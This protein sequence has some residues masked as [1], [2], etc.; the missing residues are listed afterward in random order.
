MNSFENRDNFIG[1]E[2]SPEDID[3]KIVSKGKNA[4]DTLHENIV[5]EKEKDLNLKISDIYGVDYDEASEIHIN[6]HNLRI[7]KMIERSESLSGMKKF[8]DSNFDLKNLSAQVAFG[9]ITENTCMDIL[10]GIMKN[11]K[12]VKIKDR[13]INFYS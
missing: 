1:K 2:N 8:I 4:L 12:E 9:Q 11:Q 3:D 10:I 7:R 6:Y 5:K 13:Y